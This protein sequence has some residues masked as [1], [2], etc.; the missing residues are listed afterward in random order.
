M[1][2]HSWSVVI[3]LTGCCRLRY[4]LHVK[5]VIFTAGP[6]FA[7]DTACSSS[8]FA[9]DHAVRAMRTGLCDAAIVGGSSICLNPGFTAELSKLGM[10]S[11][12]GA[13][14]SFDAS[15]QQHYCSYQFS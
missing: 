8:L 11:P 7:V 14:K 10:L 12:S 5:W 1:H 2:A 6:S 9:F 13:C 3:K 4:E 15:G